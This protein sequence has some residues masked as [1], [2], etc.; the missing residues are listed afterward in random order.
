MSD[1]NLLKIIAKIV[2]L[3]YEKIGVW[4]VIRFFVIPLVCLIPEAI[5]MTI[6]EQYME[7]M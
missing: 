5:I 1:Q 7:G 3:V 2:H 6:F 4:S